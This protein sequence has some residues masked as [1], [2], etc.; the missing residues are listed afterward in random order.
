[1][2]RRLSLGDS[3]IPESGAESGAPTLTTLAVLET[4]VLQLTR[5]DRPVFG[6]IGLAAQRHVAPPGYLSWSFI[7]VRNNVQLTIVDGVQHEHPYRQ[8]SARKPVPSD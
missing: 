8:R 4:E 6:F 1:M 7:D 5:S 3:A 2:R